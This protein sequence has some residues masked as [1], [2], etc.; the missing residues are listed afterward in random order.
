MAER[1]EAHRNTVVQ[2]PVTGCALQWFVL[3]NWY[4]LPAT[5]AGNNKERIRTESEEVKMECVTEGTGRHHS[6]LLETA[7][8]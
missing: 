2:V 3:G 5:G 4:F 7:I 8:W 1:Y 6:L